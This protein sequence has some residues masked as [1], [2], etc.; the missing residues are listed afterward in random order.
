MIDEKC[1]DETYWQMKT[2]TGL[3]ILAKYKTV[4]NDIKFA[5]ILV[6]KLEE[7]S[8]IIDIEMLES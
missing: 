7:K 5:D 1:E 8:K 3:V 2:K 6:Q 4:T